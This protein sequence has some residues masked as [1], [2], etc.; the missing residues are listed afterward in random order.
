MLAPILILALGTPFQVSTKTDAFKGA[1]LFHACQSAIQEMDHP[2][3]NSANAYQAAI[4]VSYI[5]GFMDGQDAAGK[6][7]CWM[8]AS[9]ETIVKAYVA[10]M[11]KNP[12]IMEMDRRVG[13]TLALGSTFPCPVKP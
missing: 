5:E 2:N 9:Y 1:Y 6:G 4:C 11:A 8:S 12:K 13:L 10:Y 3:D 7:A